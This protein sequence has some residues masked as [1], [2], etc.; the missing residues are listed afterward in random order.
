MREFNF[1]SHGLKLLFRTWGSGD[2]TIRLIHGLGEHSLRYNHVA[3]FFVSKGYGFAAF[4]L[5][6]HGAS[7]GKRGDGTYELMLK[8]ISK[9]LNL[10]EGRKVLYGHSMGGAL[11]LYYLLRKGDVEAAIVSAPFLALAKPLSIL[12]KFLLRLL[13]RVAPGVQTSNGIDARYLSRDEEV[14]KAYLSDPLVHNKIT[15]RLAMSAFRAAE[16]I[17]ENALKLR[18]PTLII[19][20]TADAITSFEANKKFAELAGC[21]F[22]AYEGFYHEPHNDVGKEKVLEDVARWLEGVL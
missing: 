20:G 19:H 6:G 21:D 10:C 12:Q 22:I 11:A 7:E 15:P 3:E 18:T 17:M 4:D 5:K 2:V 16:W 1:S 9:F 13:A 14:V 8:D